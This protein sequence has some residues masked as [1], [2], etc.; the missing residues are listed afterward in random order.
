[1]EFSAATGHAETDE[2]IFYPYSVSLTLFILF[3]DE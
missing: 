2:T 1:M 3:S